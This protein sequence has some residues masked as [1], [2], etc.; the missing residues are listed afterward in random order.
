MATEAFIK[1]I[2]VDAHPGECPQ[3]FVDEFMLFYDEL[4]RFFNCSGAIER[5]DAMYD[6]FEDETRAQVQELKEAMWALD[7]GSAGHDGLTGGEGQAI[8]RA[9][10]ASI[11]V[12]GIF[13]GGLST[14]MRNDAPDEAVSQRQAW[15][16]AEI[17]I[18]ELA[19]VVLARALQSSGAGV[20]GEGDEK[21]SHFANALN[22]VTRPCG[23][24]PRPPP[25]A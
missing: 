14:G 6:T 25:A 11:D 10:R 22:P 9:L 12:R 24:A 15:R 21:T 4:K 8:L 23:V 3:A 20:E 16:L 7:D 13:T 19:F 2:T 17:A 1:R 18:E 5:L